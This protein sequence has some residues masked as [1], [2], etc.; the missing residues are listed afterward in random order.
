MSFL[1]KLADWLG[2]SVPMVPAGL[3]PQFRGRRQNFRA[4]TLS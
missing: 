2:P 1:D 3:F 4:K